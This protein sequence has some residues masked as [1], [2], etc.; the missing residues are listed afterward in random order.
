MAQVANPRKQFQ[1]TIIIPGLNPFL[2]QEVK[3]PDADYDTVEHGD[4]GYMVKTAGMKKIGPLN[5]NKI[6]PAD[7]TDTYFRDWQTRILQTDQGGGQLPSQYKVPILV[8]EYSSD[9]ITVVERYLFR[10]CWPQ[11]L[12]GK[13]LNRKGSDNTMQSIDFQV[14]QDD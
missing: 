13:D 11:K 5:I 3:M 12:N 14:D 7:S 1:F 10:G 6:S 9:G 8:E 4:T 2:A